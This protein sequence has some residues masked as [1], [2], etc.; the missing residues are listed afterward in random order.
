MKIIAFDPKSVCGTS[1]LDQSRLGHHVNSVSLTDLP[2]LPHGIVIFGLADDTGIKNVGGRIG[3]KEGPISARDKLYKFTTG[4]PG[5][6][7]YD[8]GNIFAQNTIEETHAEATKIIKKIH[9]SG[10][11]PLVFGGGHDLAFPE[12]LALLEAKQSN[13]GFLNIDAHLDLRPTNNGITSGSPWFLLR[14]HSLFQKTKSKILEFGIQVHCNAQTLLD[15]AKKNK[16]EIFWWQT[17]TNRKKDFEKAL[18]SLSRL[19][20]VQVSLDIDSV[21]SSEAPGV[22]AP[23]TIGFSPEEVIFMSKTSGKNTKV[24]SF[25]IYELSPPLDEDGRTARLVAHCAAAFIAG[26]SERLKRAKK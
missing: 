6:P 4:K 22:S 17:L 20:N 15:Y 5:I 12:A 24:C 25:G 21:M 9:E 13:S 16:I 23:Q 14:E 11:C 7:V 19:K 26:Y 3:A 1:N 8:L 18:K 2:T 10:H